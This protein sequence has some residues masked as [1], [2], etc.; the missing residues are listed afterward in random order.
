MPGVNVEGGITLTFL[1]ASVVAQLVYWP[2]IVV[3]VLAGLF[4]PAWNRVWWLALLATVIDFGLMLLPHGEF[5]LLVLQKNWLYFLGT[6]YPAAV[7]HVLVGSWIR[8]RLFRARP[9]EV[10][11]WPGRKTR[12]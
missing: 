11:A 1:V 12:R 4:A 8:Q 2:S 3:G 6:I 9:P 5:G 10:K 7:V